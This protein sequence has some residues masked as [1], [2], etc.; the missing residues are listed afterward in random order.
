[1]FYKTKP[2]NTMLH[3]IVSFLPRHEA[4]LLS[5]VLSDRSRVSNLVL[6]WKPLITSSNPSGCSLHL[7]RFSSFKSIILLQPHLCGEEHKH[8]PIYSRPFYMHNFSTC[9]IMITLGEQLVLYTFKMT[10]MTAFMLWILH[11]KP[12]ANL[13]TELITEKIYVTEIYDSEVKVEWSIFMYI[14]SKKAV[15]VPHTSPSPSSPF[16]RITSFF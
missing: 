14:Y 15:K 2:K 9:Q 16:T 11:S 13:N 12:A 7:P 1:M 8:H 10:I 4:L 3:C 5:M 6:T